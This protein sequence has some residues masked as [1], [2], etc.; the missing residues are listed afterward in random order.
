MVCNRQGKRFRK[1]R[2]LTVLRDDHYSYLVK[3][4][5]FGFLALG[6]FGFIAYVLTSR[7]AL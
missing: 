7:G 3:A 1:Q 2:K 5:P 4:I 6:L